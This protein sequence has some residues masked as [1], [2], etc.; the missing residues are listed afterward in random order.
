MT[1]RCFFIILSFVVP[2][3]LQAQLYRVFYTDKGENIS[4]NV[5]SPV[6]PNYISGISMYCDSIWMSSRWLNY[7]LIKNST[8]PS[9]I[10]NL[11]FVSH[12]ETVQPSTSIELLEVNP[13]QKINSKTIETH[14]QWQLDTLGYPFFKKYDLNGENITIAIIDA[15]FSG[16][17]E[18]TAFE[19]IYR[20]NRLLK[21]WDFIDNDSNVYHGASHGTMVWSC[22]AGNMDNK[23][24][25]LATNASF[26]LLRSED[27]KTET[28]GDEDRWIQ[29]LEK[30]HEWGAD[31]VNSS[32]GFSNAL[33]KRSEVNGESMISKAANIA[34][35]KGM[36]VVVSAGNEFITAWKTLSI[37]ADA[38]HVITVGGI[39][40]EGTQSY[41]SSVG[42]T[43]DGR[44]K[45]D[46]VAP[47]TCVVAYNNQFIIANGTSFAAPLVTGYLACMLQWK[48]KGNFNRDS[49]KSYGGLFPYFDH[50]Y[51]YG[52][53]HSPLEKKDSVF[54]GIKCNGPVIN[55]DKKQISNNEVLVAMNP[56]HTQTI[57]LKIVDINGRIKFSNRYTLRGKKVYRI[58]V[59]N[60]RSRF[61]HSKYLL[62]DAGDKWY[63]WTGYCF[64]EYIFNKN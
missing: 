39:S 4:N 35:Q 6:N 16:A 57:F 46:V 2:G 24:T 5:D 1:L 14:R 47:G 51:G 8:Y 52:V 18:N 48:G 41:F 34:A 53:P 36:L 59:S 58:P 3:L 62:P 12:I 55:K 44:S 9:E 30:A 11:G 28:M 43:F 54:G 22:I 7:S 33:H 50:V 49:I 26:I 40:K 21:T 42:P 61:A 10:E 25:G 32:I 64:Y 37:P 20:N 27:Q 29:A 56:L 15:G 17:N 19:H 38:E 45:P 13:H 31:I 23:P 63:V 60:K